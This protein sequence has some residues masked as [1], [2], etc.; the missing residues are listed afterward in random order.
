[1]RYWNLQASILRTTAFVNAPR[2]FYF[3]IT[4]R[5]DNNSRD[6]RQG[7]C[8]PRRRTNFTVLPLRLMRHLNTTTVSVPTYQFHSARH[9][10]VT[11][12]IFV[13]LKRRFPVRFKCWSFRDNHR[14]VTSVYWFIKSVLNISTVKFTATDNN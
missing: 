7:G 12:I 8:G 5:C 3:F 4:S 11:N 2:P 1:M 6:C 14:L 10:N 9:W 13:P